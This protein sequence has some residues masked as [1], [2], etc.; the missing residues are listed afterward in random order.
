VRERY[1][2]ERGRDIGEREGVKGGEKERARR[3]RGSTDFLEFRDGHVH[4]GG[5]STSYTVRSPCWKMGYSPRD[6][7]SVLVWGMLVGIRS[8]RDLTAR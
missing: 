6:T 2:D 1:R 5:Q 3:E 4:S 7:I 8:S